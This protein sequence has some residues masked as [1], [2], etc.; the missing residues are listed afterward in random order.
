ME[1]YYEEE[2]IEHALS[3]GGGRSGLVTPPI[4]EGLPFLIGYVANRHEHCQEET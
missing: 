3:L 1:L 2:L 4:P